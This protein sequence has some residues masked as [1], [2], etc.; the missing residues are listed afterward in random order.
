MEATATTTG[1][2]T[3]AD[4][5]PSAA[6]EHAEKAAVRYKRDGAWQDVSYTQLAD[7][8]GEIGLG[9]I[10]LGVQAGERVCILANTRPEWSY[11][12]MAATSAGAVVVPIYQTNS[13]EECLWVISDSGA[14]AIVCEDDEQL[15]KIAA[16]RDQV[17][18][19]RTII[20]MDTPG[21][22]PAG[23]GAST[24]ERQLDAITLEEVRERGRTHAA[25]ELEA[26]RAAVKPEDPFT[27]IYTSGTTG[28]P[29]GCVLTHG[30]YRAIIDMIREAGEIEQD[31][32]IYLYLPLAHSYA[33][34]I[35]LAVFDLGGTLA[36]FGGDTKQIVPELLEVKPTY[37]PSVPR[38]FEKIYTLAQ[39]AIQS[40]S[41]EE[42]EQA[43]QAIA[44]GMK[45]RDMVNRGEEVPEEL[46]APFEQADEQ[47]FKNVRAIF[48]GDVRRATSGAAPIAREILEFFWACGVPV[49]EGYGMTETATAATVSTIENHRFGTV[50]R[51]LPGV[52]LKIAEDGE[53]LIKGPNI[54]HGYHNMASTS[55]GSVE[56]G[57]LHTGDLGAIDEDGYLSITGRKK[58]IIITAGGKNLTPANLENDLKQCR[59]I[60]QA[61]MH[62]DQ[63]PYPVVLITL[64]E[65]E[66]PIYAREHGL[67]EDIASLAKDPAIRELIQ[68]EIDRVNAK[69]AQVEQV[70]KF[71]ILDHDLSQPTGELTP[72][73][74][75]KRNVVNEKYSGVFDSLYAG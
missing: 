63:R 39:G 10:D 25:E 48:G 75:V 22:Q 9:L 67:P 41:P 73:L 26:R 72:T 21:G 27:F 5:I 16:V 54:F 4:L 42:Q 66:I 74:K 69:Y 57:W 11:V 20:V 14:C 65:E 19:L 8:V 18:N 7:I 37:L 30:N 1:S 17:P 12:D 23:N 52:E 34:L 35:Q 3:I 44:L 56:Q 40:K 15:A 62:G 49:L 31:E 68:R 13:P 24:I 70:K 61:V 47:L 2:K 71:A 46:K 59:W 38:V 60:S 33:L 6:G 50:G 36:Y 64:D 29:K 32:I 43:R 53:I 58:D 55:F 28:P 45:V 51:A